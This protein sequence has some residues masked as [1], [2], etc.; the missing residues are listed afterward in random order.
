VESSTFGAAGDAYLMDLH[1]GS[2]AH[3]TQEDI[4]RLSEHLMGR[5]AT[6]EEVEEARAAFEGLRSRLKPPEATEV[7][8]EKH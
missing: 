5:P 8:G 7:R 3:L 2:P 1:L 6:P 4:I